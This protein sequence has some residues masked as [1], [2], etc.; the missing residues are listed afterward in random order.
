MAVKAVPEKSVIF[1]DMDARI[2]LFPLGSGQSALSNNNVAAHHSF[3]WPIHNLSPSCR[4][5]A[6]LC[7][8][9]ATLKAAGV[10]RKGFG[11]SNG[12]TGRKQPRADPGRA[13]RLW[14]PGALCAARLLRRPAL[15]HVLHHIVAQAAG[16]RGRPRYHRLLRLGAAAAHLQIPVG[17]LA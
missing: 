5:K 8:S 14:P 6:S 3:C 11:E 13:E 9:A 12:V 2:D 4:R 10:L 1:S 17:A 7:D 16:A 15:L